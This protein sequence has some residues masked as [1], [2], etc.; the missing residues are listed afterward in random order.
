MAIYPHLS[1]VPC[2]VWLRLFGS[3]EQRI[4]VLSENGDSVI[5]DLD[6]QEVLAGKGRAGITVRICLV[7]S[8]WA[9]SAGRQHAG[10]VSAE[11]SHGPVMTEALSGSGVC[12]EVRRQSGPLYAAVYRAD[13]ELLVSQRAYGVLPGQAPVLHLRGDAHGPLAAAY[14]ESFE[15]LWASQKHMR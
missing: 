3:A 1:D 9:D 5:G 12:M 10:G 14:V 6:V 2:D 8:E 13:D 11:A 15:R 7:D 4:D